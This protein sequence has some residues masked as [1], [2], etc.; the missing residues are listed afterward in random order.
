MNLNCGFHKES[1]MKL[2]WH[3]QF[4][5]CNTPQMRMLFPGEECI[6]SGELGD[7]PSHVQLNAHQ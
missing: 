6:S 5:K 3:V 4:F 7:C 1:I 2:S